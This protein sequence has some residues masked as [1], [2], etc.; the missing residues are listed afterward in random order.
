[1]NDRFKDFFEVTGKA[2]KESFAKL[3]KVYI[4]Q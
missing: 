3:N 2:L 4:A 1:M